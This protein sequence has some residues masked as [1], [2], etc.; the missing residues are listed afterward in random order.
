[1]QIYELVEQINQ[2]KVH[3]EFYLEFSQDPQGF[4]TRWLASQ[5]HDLQVMTDAV[6]GHPE[7]ER[8]AEFYSA[9]WMQEAVKRY[10][11]NRVA[12]SKHSVGAIAHY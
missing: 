3:R 2:M 12:G 8:R 9:S 4:I 11:Y 10:F 5:S 6:P 1:M 7:E